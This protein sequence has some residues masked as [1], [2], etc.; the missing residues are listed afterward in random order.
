MP[1]NRKG[2]LKPTQARSREKQ[3]LC[4]RPRPMRADYLFQTACVKMRR[5]RL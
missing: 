4:S 1:Q 5:Y 2:R 3:P